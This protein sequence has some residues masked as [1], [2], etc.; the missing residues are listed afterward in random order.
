MLDFKIVRAELG[1]FN[2]GLYPQSRWT[3]DELDILA[4]RILRILP[5]WDEPRFRKACD[6]HALR[7]KL[8][9]SPADLVAAEKASEAASYHELAALPAWD[10]DV[11]ARC[12]KNQ[13]RA[14]DMVAALSSGKRPPWATTRTQ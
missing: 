12:A 5:G 4:G 9:P 14:K 1:Q 6:A 2:L 8:P 7:S 10:T 11:D 13:S 3:P